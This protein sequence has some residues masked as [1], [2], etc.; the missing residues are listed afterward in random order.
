LGVQ[1]IEAGWPAAS[2]EDEAAVKGIVKRNLG[3]QIFC[4]TRCMADDL[5]RAADCGVHGVITSVPGSKLYL[6]LGLGWSFE[7]ATDVAIKGTKL[8]NELGL[9]VLFSLVDGTRADMGQ[10]LS[11]IE[12]IAKEGHIDSLCLMDTKGCLTPEAVAY[13]IKRIKK[14][15][16]KPLEAHF[17]NDLGLGVANTVKAVL[18]GVEVIH[19]TVNGLGERAGNTP[20]EETVMALLTLYG[21]NTGIKY[22]K[23]RELAKLV[24]EISG[25]PMVPNRSIVGDRLSWI[26]SG[27]PVEHYRKIAEKVNVDYAKTGMFTIHPAFV[28]NKEPEVVLGKKSGRGN[29]LVWAEKFGIELSQEELTDV[30]MAVKALAYKKRGL[31]NEAEFKKIV[32]EVKATVK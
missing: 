32:E 9:Y 7:K 31:L 15:V 30:L 11:M 27:M 24:E 12:Q 22:E 13:A 19:T 10:Y 14:L 8:A 5:R 2:P 6:E 20:M 28:G 18:S 29:I 25:V 23:L 26:E 3:P 16:R 1:R 4:A 21:I 17:H